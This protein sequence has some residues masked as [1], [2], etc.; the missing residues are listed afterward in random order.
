M[1]VLLSPRVVGAFVRQ[2]SSSAVQRK[3]ACTAAFSGL[4]S[5]PPRRIPSSPH[6]HLRRSTTSITSRF[7][8][9]EAANH[10]PVEE[11]QEEQQGPIDHT[12]LVDF[13]SSSSSES[14][15]LDSY[16][17]P[18]SPDYIPLE[19]PGQ[20]LVC[21]GDVHGDLPALKQFLKVAGVY[22]ND[23]DT[24]ENCWTGG[25][26]VLVQCG[27][28]TD[29]GDEEL[30]CFQL[31]AKLG[32]E[33]KLAGG[34]VVM[35]YGNHEAMNA[36]GLF[37]YAY[38]AGNA[39]FESKVGTNLLDKALG[40]V[41]WRA[42]Y[43]G[44]VPAR[45]AAM[46]PGGILAKTLLQ[47]FKV[48]VQVG[49]T[50]CVHAGL[51]EQ[52]LKDYGGVEGMNK[53]AREWIVDSAS[54]LDEEQNAYGEFTSVDQVMDSAQRRA[55]TIVSAMPPCLGGGIGAKSPVWMRD[56]SQPAD[57][58]PKNPDAQSMADAALDA[59]DGDRMVMG[60]T[61]QRRI[62][63]ALQG[64]VWRVDVGASRGVNSGTPEVLEVTA[65][66]DGTESVHILTSSGQRVDAM[67]DR[68]IKSASTVDAKLY[69]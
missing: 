27:D 69:F 16:Q 41:R 4:V 3:G 36:A 46:E 56:Y 7:L 34:Q 63:G 20:R 40:T 13:V 52:H 32:R 10:Q 65:N 31:L 44:N 11:E 67:K 30:A 61:P 55:K 18:E 68:L 17:L 25:D 14:N 23:N 39:E 35:L 9:V 60:H 26:T 22:N 5:V 37:Q 24:N 53:A 28:I 50:V 21:I 33:A 1:L 38:P 42:Q 51:T 54:L 8:S 45:W 47:Q 48:A 64:K 19:R 59:V 43:A 6:A 29:R 62:N 12:P 66:S 57:M 15:F 58:P 2:S 49:K